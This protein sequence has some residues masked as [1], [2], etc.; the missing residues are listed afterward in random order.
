MAD[1]F[2]FARLHNSF[3]VLP[4]RL[5]FFYHFSHF[6]YYFRITT[7]LSRRRHFTKPAAGLISSLR[8][9]P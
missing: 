5:P 2:S 7:L 6:F 1:F 3:T 8:F 9:L 4:G